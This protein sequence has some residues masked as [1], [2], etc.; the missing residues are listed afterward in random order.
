[1][2]K[3]APIIV[4]VYNRL[5]HTQKTIKALQNNYLAKDSDL[6]VYSDA[7][8]K[9]AENS[10]VEQVR[11]YI[12]SV[13]GFK[14][15]S[16]IEQT[17][18]K[19][20]A[21]S[22]ITGVTNVVNKYG[23]V[24]VLEDDLVTAPNFLTYMN[25]AL[26]KY[27]K[28]TQVFSIS[29]YSYCPKIADST[30]FLKLTTSWGWATW[31]R[32]WKYFEKNSIELS[33]Y[34]KNKRNK[35]K[36]DYDNSYKFSNFI[37]LKT[38]W[39]L[40]WYF[41]SYK[42]D[43][44]TLYPRNSLV[45]NIGFDGSGVHSTGQNDKAI[46]PYEYELTD[47]ITEKNS[48]KKL[49]I[50]T[51]KSKNI[52]NKLKGHIPTSLRRKISRCVTE[53]KLLLLNPRNIKG[54]YIDKSVHVLGW[55]SVKIGNGTAISEGCWL[56]VNNRN[57]DAIQI[58]VG[59]YSYLGKRNF[60]SSGKKVVIQDY[61]MSG[62]NCQFLGSDH[63]MDS[64]LQPY[65]STGTTSENI[66]NVGVNNWFGANVTVVGN[67][68][69]GRG[70]II[71]TCAL[72][73]KDIPPFSIAVGSPAVVIKRFDFKEMKWTNV[74]QYD[75]ALDEFMPSDEEYLKTLQKTKVNVPFLAASKSF[76]DLL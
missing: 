33:D 48:N 67:V 39:A 75:T 44:L 35:Y 57:I 37:S 20:L 5:D 18:N 11:R 52:F 74:E 45:Q 41:S 27:E 8:A 69:I 59:N 64:P 61:F 42:N 19:G 1:L 21:E 43:G 54:T 53:I 51:F 3:Y 68:S 16:I 72:V 49:V 62:V 23:K 14:S 6:F 38:T 28:E 65:I 32:K 76:G 46:T 26:T 2:K 63:I 60:I 40:Y 66:I 58:E 9:A 15:V 17:S 29:G 34:L 25:D 31:D 36:F 12:H 4:F 47:N 50:K 30:Y 70:S 56:N 24:I 13:K 55:E 10:N 22:V 73:T 7:A 71:G